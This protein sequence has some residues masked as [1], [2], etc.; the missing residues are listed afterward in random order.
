MKENSEKAIESLLEASLLV[1]GTTYDIR[2]NYMDFY[3]HIQT[4]V[5]STLG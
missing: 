4:Q 2:E 5:S 3:F 1:E